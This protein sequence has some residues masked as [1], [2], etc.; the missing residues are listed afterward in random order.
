MVNIKYCYKDD[1]GIVFSIHGVDV[2]SMQ[3][4][5]GYFLYNG[6]LHPLKYSTSHNREISAS[7]RALLCAYVKNIFRQN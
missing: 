4:F 1:L 6:L 5:K 7:A 3:K 2:I